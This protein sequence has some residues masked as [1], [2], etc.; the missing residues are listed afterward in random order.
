MEE[1]LITRRV[2]STHWRQHTTWFDEE[3][4]LFFLQQV[5]ASSGRTWWRSRWWDEENWCTPGSQLG[6]L[7]AL[8]VPSPTLHEQ[9]G[10]GDVHAGGTRHGGRDWQGREHDGGNGW[11][12]RQLSDF[13]GTDIR[14]NLGGGGAQ[15]GAVVESSAAPILQVVVDTHDRFLQENNV[16]TSLLVIKK[17]RKKWLVMKICLPLWGERWPEQVF[18][19][20]IPREGSLCLL[21]DVQQMEEMT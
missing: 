11:Q 7:Q 5:Q 13:L 16:N 14:E 3:E 4:T 1:S 21:A 17:P 8:A 10:P 18:P 6:S 12:L 9:R 2:K 20:R 19:D 15:D